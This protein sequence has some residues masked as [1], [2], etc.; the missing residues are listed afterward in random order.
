ML[1]LRC[2]IPFNID[3]IVQEVNRTGDENKAGNDSYRH[4]KLNLLLGKEH[5][6]RQTRFLIH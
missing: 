3:D 4:S 6:G 2:T 1:L 5:P